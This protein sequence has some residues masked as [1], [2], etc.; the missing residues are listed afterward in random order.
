[1]KLDVSK[2][3]AKLTALPKT[4]E[5]DI[6][7]SLE[8]SGEDLKKRSQAVAPYRPGDTV[9]LREKAYSEVSRGVGGPTLEVGYNGPRGYLFVQHEG[10]WLNHMG[11]RGPVD[12]NNYTTP[13][14]GSHFLSGPWARYKSRYVRDLKEDARKG[15]R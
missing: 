5:R 11:Y 12:I 3:T 14:T 13:G 15:L 10:S 6:R 8:E 1:M 4:T 7:D 9:H 2:L